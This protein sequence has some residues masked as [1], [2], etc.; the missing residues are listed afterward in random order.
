MVWYSVL[1]FL[2]WCEVCWH[3]RFFHRMLQLKTN[4]YSILKNALQLP[5]IYLK[6]GF[7]L[8]VF[9]KSSSYTI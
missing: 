3:C 1:F 2:V 5:N 4:L 7:I 9:C 6:L 8:L